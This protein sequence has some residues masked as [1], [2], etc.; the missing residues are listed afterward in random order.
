MD[1]VFCNQARAYGAGA[2]GGADLSAVMLY[3]QLK[4]AI[5]SVEK[6][7]ADDEILK[8]IWYDPAGK[9]V[10][11]THIGYYNQSLI[12]FCGRD[13]DGSEC[14]ALVPVHL[15]QLVLKKA[16]KQLQEGRS[17]MSFIGNSVVPELPAAPSP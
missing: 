14:T 2:T 7:V 10:V 12:V 5:E 11:V 1:E 8:A 16:K 4:E 15:A 13:D 6:T 3:E 17:S 9:P